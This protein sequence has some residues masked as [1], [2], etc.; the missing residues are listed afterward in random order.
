MQPWNTVEYLSTISSDKSSSETLIIAS[1]KRSSQVLHV[2]V[3]FNAFF[4]YCA[5]FI[6]LFNND[7][8]VES[9]FGSGDFRL[10]AI[11]Q[12]KSLLKK[13]SLVEIMNLK[14]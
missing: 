10:V 14:R 8:H 2:G 11:L 5:L 12:N 7:R 9:C 3:P 4:H 6:G 13:R 1:L